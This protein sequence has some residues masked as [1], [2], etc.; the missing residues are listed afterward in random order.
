M[1]LFKKNMKID[2]PSNQ[3]VFQMVTTYGEHFYSWN[4][5]VYESDVV[6]ACIRPKVQ[7]VGKLL[8]KHIREDRKKSI[9]VNP[10]P[11]IKFLLKEPNP[12]MTGQMLQEK[13]TTQLCLNNNAFALV[14]R[15]E[16]GKASQ[17]YPIPAVCVE[18]KYSNTGELLLKFQFKNG[19]SSIFR[20]T[21]IIHLR[22]DYYSDDIFGE[23]PAPALAEM[24]EVICT[25]DQGLIKA[26]KNS[27]IVRWLL[28][29]NNSL[30]PDDLKK[31]V[32]AF[33]ENYL[34]IESDTFGAAGVDSKATATRIE[35][36]D[37]A[38]NSEQMDKAIDRIYSFFNTNKKIVQSNWTEDEWNAYYEAEIEPVAIQIGEVYSTRIF[39]RK[40]RGYGNQIIFEA[41]NLQCASLKTKLEFVAMVDRGAMVPDE[42]RWLMNLGPIEGGNKPIRRLDTQVVNM[43]EELLAKMNSENHGELVKLMLALLEGAEK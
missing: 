38:P 30:R 7:A 15:D 23:S 13:L 8:G 39:S 14:V 17:I 34:S 31:N 25:L 42:W 27:G 4:G 5:K 3:Q 36:K 21:D 22:R 18:T 20:Y 43:M 16:N 26:V 24:M 29:F 40:E 33:V 32:K 35:P 12:Y 6:R 1:P 11:Y 37:Y 19:K 2:K 9:Q 10:D 28:S 41:S